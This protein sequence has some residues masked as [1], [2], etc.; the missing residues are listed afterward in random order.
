[1]AMAT[2]SWRFRA[3]SPREHSENTDGPAKPQVFR[4]GGAEIFF[5]SVAADSESQPARTA[6]HY[7]TCLIKPLGGHNF[8][9]VMISK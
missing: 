4:R 6:P 8:H 1:M 9:P 5:W 2:P 7:V 3:E